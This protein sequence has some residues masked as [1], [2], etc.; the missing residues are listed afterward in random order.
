MSKNKVII[1]KCDSYKK[2]EVGKSVKNIF[3]AFEG[4]DTLFKKDEKI[5]IKINLLKASSPEKAIITHPEVAY[6]VSKELFDYGAKPYVLDSPGAGTLYTEESLR[7][8]Y[9]KTGYA[10]IFKDSGMVLNSDITYQSV[11]ISKGKV[12]KYLDIITPIMQSDGV[13]NIAKGKTHGFTYISAAVK[14]L[15]G[16]IPGMYKAGYH[17]KLRDVNFFSEMLVDIAELIRPKLSII[18]AVVCMEGNGPADGNPRNVGY[19]IASDSPFA[20]DYVFCDIIGFDYR[21]NPVLMKAE[22]RGLFD[23]NNVI[24]E[25][26]YDKIKKFVFPDTAVTLDGFVSP[27]FLF[28]VYRILFKDMLT[29]R[30]VINENCEACGICKTSC[31]VGAITIEGKKAVINYK[32]CIRCYCCHEMCN[33]HAV[34]FHKGFTYKLFKKL[35]KNKC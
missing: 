13:I 3:K 29:L 8:V 35:L 27:S 32:E 10:E 7:N 24:V 21:K 16:I 25:G 2:E 11:K 9:K 33:S 22:A 34:E 28:K 12:V 15:F 6:A 5:A 31:P 4:I 14:N 20:A 23:K 17:A 19:L 18:D 1:A 26:N 30:P